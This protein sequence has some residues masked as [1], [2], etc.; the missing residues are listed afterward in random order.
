MVRSIYPSVTWLQ[1]RFSIRSFSIYVE[2]PVILY[3]ADPFRDITQI[4]ANLGSNKK[5][6]VNVF[7]EYRMSIL[8]RT[9]DLNFRFFEG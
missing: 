9:L 1:L 3:T 2:L 4:I 8:N 6:E 5:F 7:R